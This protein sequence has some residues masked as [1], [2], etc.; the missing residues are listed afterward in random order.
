M[1]RSEREMGPRRPPLSHD[2]G[3]YANIDPGI[4][5]DVVRFLLQDQRYFAHHAAWN[6]CGYVFHCDGLW[7]EEVW[8]Y[9][10]LVAIYHSGSIAELIK[11]VNDNHGW[12]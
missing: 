12:D 11:Q 6:F 8:V 3:I 9:H 7:H 4:N 5:G 10:T 2:R 1:P